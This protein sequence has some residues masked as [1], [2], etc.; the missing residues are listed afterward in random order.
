MFYDR[1]LKDGR[2]PASVETECD[3]KNGHQ[4]LIPKIQACARGSG[5]N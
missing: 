1:E 3:I 4:K 2:N 5:I